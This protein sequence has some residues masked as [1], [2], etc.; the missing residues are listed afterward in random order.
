MYKLFNNYLKYFPRFEKY[1][2]G[3]KIQNLIIELLI[4]ALKTTY[5]PKDKKLPLLNKI[6]NKVFILKTLM[7]LAKEVKSLDIKK[8]IFIEEKLL[9]IG[10]MVGG[11]IRSTQQN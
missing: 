2:L 10:K 1:T 7:R 11:W 3:E 5:L 6:D 4:T 8:Y 9:G